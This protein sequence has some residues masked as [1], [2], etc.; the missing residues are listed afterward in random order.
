M[1]EEG[2]F[3]ELKKFAANGGAFFGTCA[4]TILMARDV[5]GPAQASLGLIDISVL[6]NAYGRQLASDV[7][8]GRTKLHK[9]PLEMVF[10]RAPII[11]SVGKGVEVLAED[12][13]HPVL[14]QQGKMLAATFH[15][16]LTSDTAVHEH[17][18]QMA[19][20]GAKS[21]SKNGH[22]HSSSKH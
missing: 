20:N 8:E 1:T 11:E 18:I 3:D 21:S 17:F 12:A 9:E 15:P 5:H 2:L 6:R 7:H 4:G 19:Q 22:G 14:V 13:G 16:E 10:I